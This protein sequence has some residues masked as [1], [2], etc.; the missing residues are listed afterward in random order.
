M[1]TDFRD[2]EAIAALRHNTLEDWAFYDAE[3]YCRSELAELNMETSANI[4]FAALL[5]AMI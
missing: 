4:T 3:C 5:K 2:F 1:S